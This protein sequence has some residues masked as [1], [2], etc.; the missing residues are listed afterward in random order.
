MPAVSVKNLRKTYVE[1]SWRLWEEERISRTHAIQGVTFDV[2][3]GEIFGIV[4]PNGAGKTTLINMI[5]GLLYK[6]SG[7]IKVFDKDL[8]RNREELSE[9]MN[10]ATAYSWLQGRLTLE[11][12]LRVFGKIY[13]VNNLEER[14]D[15]LLELFEVKH[16]REK[17]VHNFSTGQR[18]RAN[19]CKG[20]INSPELLLLDEVTAGLD[21]YIADITRKTIQKINRERGTTIIMTSHNMTDIDELSDRMMF[22]HNGRILKIGRPEEVK[23]DIHLKLLRI[24]FEEIGPEVQN[25]LEERECVAR[26]GIVDFLIDKE[27]D[28]KQI[29]DEVH[30]TGAKII[31][32][33]IEKPDLEKLFKKVAEDEG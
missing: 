20:L 26:E 11:E 6:D 1:R 16:L 23:K 31:D 8:A 19:I 28:I 14:I 27:R 33:D 4:G 18:T 30:Q 10:V 3:E 9:R 7:Q 17:K 15:E 12:N 13:H 24:Q 5:S 25:I 21:P 22:L 29:L 2:E 32:I